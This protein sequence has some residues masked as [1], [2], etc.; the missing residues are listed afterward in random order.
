M[1]NFDLLSASYYEIKEVKYDYAVLPWGATEP[2]NYHLPYLTDCY[3]SHDL[4]IDAVEQA[5]AQHGIRGMVLPPVTLGSQNPGQYDIL[6]CIHARYETQKA[7]L[8]DVIASLSRQGL[9]KL[10]IVNGHGGNN[11]KNMVRDL[12]FD[13]PSFSVFVVDWYKIVPPGDYFD[14]AGDHADEMET[15]VLMHYRPQLVNLPVAG[16]GHS[17]AFQS[18]ALNEGVGWIP[19]DWS[20]ISQ[21]TGVGNP[22]RST[23]AKGKEYAGAVTGKLVKLFMETVTKD[24]W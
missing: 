7:I 8:S 14:A 23:A 3:L 18:R 5:Y 20:K 16:D 22:H 9:S 2:H 24:I 13:Y 17:K 11:F 21:D 6:F 4:S 1:N 15:S 19:R 10:F 12:A